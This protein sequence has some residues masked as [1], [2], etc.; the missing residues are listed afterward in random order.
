M[1]K[2]AANNRRR[3]DIYTIPREDQASLD[4]LGYK[5]KLDEVD[6]AILVNADFLAHI[7]ANPEIFG[8][9]L[10]NDEDKTDDWQPDNR[11][12]VGERFAL[13]T[14]FDVLIPNIGRSS[15]HQHSHT[16]GHIHDH[17]HS[18]SHSHSTPGSGR[19]KKFKPTDF[20]MDKLRSTLK[21]FVRDWSEEVRFIVICRSN[22][23]V[24]PFKGLVE[25]SA[26]YQ[27]MV[28]ALVRHYPT[29]TTP[30]ER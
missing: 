2:L 23:N 4:A 21:Q 11:S 18:H 15:D 5:A 22:S 3:R 26:C 9:D 30:E 6:K 12:S 27:P 16:S 25:R 14:V 10:E 24:D 29:A 20:D 7:V 8:H 17:S 13:V 1:L 28:D 19:P